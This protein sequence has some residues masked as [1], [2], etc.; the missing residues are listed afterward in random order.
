[1]GTKHLSRH[2]RQRKI[3]QTLFA[4][5]KKSAKTYTGVVRDLTLLGSAQMKKMTGETPEVRSYKREGKTDRILD[6]IDIMD[7]IDR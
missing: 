3:L 5:R 1:M 4:W 7:L 2:L 6:I